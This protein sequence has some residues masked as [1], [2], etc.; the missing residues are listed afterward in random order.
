[1]FTPQQLEQITFHT[2]VF[3]GYDM[4]SVD[5]FL[6]AL[7][8][9]YNTLYK[10][11]ATLKSKM[12]VLVEKL[13]EYRAEEGGAKENLRAAQ[14]TCDAMIREA[15]AKCLKMLHQAEAQAPNTSLAEAKTAAREGIEALETQL[16]EGGSPCSCC[17]S[18]SGF[19]HRRSLRIW[20]HA[21]LL[22]PGLCHQGGG[23]S[24][25]RCILPQ[26]GPRP[27]LGLRRCRPSVLGGGNFLPFLC[28][29]P[30]LTSVLTPNFLIFPFLWH[31]PSGQTGICGI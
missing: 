20:G 5:E 15:E 26:S 6:V 29:H 8:E 22:H 9:D 30:V 23:L 31:A 16:K 21:A 19:C 25:L 7:I 17:R 1:M 11:N 10:D 24:S 13:E 27:G 28:I 14:Q 2:S 3:G 4:D 12:R 18:E